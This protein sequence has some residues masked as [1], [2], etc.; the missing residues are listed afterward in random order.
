MSG[1]FMENISFFAKTFDSL[2]ISDHGTFFVKSAHGSCV[3]YANMLAL[4]R[5]NL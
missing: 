2:C 1:F 4:Y 3:K 5:D